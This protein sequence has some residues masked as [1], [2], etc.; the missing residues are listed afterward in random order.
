MI[1]APAFPDHTGGIED[2]VVKVD[3]FSERSRLAASQGQCDPYRYDEFPSPLRV[4]IARVAERA[5]GRDLRS[6]GTFIREHEKSSSYVLW[7]KIREILLDE[8]GK[9]MLSNS[10]HPMDD[11][12][13]YFKYHATVQESCDITEL[14]CRTINIVMDKIHPSAFKSHLITQSPDEALNEINLRLRRAGIGYQ[15]EGNSLVRVDSNVL[16]AE[17][18]IPAIQLLRHDRLAAAGAEYAS[19]HRHYRADEY[20][21]SLVECS[22]ALESVLKVV[23]EHHGWPFPPNATAST[24]IDLIMTRGLLPKSVVGH[25]AAIRATLEQ[26]APALR[27]SMAAHGKGSSERH[28]SEHIAAY[29]L[30]ITGSA[31]ILLVRSSGLN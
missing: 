14:L 20:E 22:K 1:G 23:C 8:Y 6:E 3:L 4:Q 28:I 12:L 30:H 27:N 2:L 18:V 11:V 16:H 7:A 13:G 19:A 5:I 24:L 9:E 29:A 17:V 10:T 25:M 26:G 31:I 21:Q 15:F